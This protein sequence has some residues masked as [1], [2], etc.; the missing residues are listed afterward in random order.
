M[1]SCRTR[2]QRGTVTSQVPNNRNVIAAVVA[3]SDQYAVCTAS[4]IPLQRFGT[5]VARIQRY[6]IDCLPE[7]PLNT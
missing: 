6:G 3:I 1:P 4:Q 7:L 2:S 5:L